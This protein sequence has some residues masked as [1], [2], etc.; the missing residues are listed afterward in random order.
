MNLNTTDT[1]GSQILDYE[2]DTDILVQAKF[3]STVRKLQI[4]ST[5]TVVNIVIT[6]VRPQLQGNRESATL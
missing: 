1:H 4:Q 2:I 6:K 5:S 3:R